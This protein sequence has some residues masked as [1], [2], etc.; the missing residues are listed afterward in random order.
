M[1]SADHIVCRFHVT[2]TCKKYNVVILVSC[3]GLWCQC[4]SDGGLAMVLGNFLCHRVLPIL[5][6][7]EKDL[8]C[9]QCCLDIFF[10]HHLSFLFP[11]SRKSLISTKLITQRVILPTTTNQPVQF[12]RKGQLSKALVES[13]QDIC[14]V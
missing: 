1:L 5:I 10:S 6:K 14:S 13:V 7:E 4:W 12:S 3:L 8:L 2:G 11:L 9:L